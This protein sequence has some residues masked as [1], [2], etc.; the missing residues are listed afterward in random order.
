MLI[1]ISKTAVFAVRCVM[2]MRH[3]AVE[4]ASTFCFRRIIVRP[5]IHIVVMV[6]FA[7]AERASKEIWMKIIVEVAS[8]LAL[9]QRRAVEVNV[10]IS[11]EQLCNVIL[12]ESW[13]IAKPATVYVDQGFLALGD[14]AFHAPLG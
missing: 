13:L 4:H 11:T 10:T 5:V 7:V 14:R 3:V 12:S 8:I 9:P 1:Q 2:K 6:K